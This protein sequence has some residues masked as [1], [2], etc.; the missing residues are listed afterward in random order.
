MVGSIVTDN[1]R[2][3]GFVSHIVHYGDGPEE[4]VIQWDDGTLGIRY[5]R[6]DKLALVGRAS[7]EVHEA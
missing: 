5:S 2:R 3:S 7:T 1:E 6:F 4:L